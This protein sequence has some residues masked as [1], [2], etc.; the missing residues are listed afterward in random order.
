M[1]PAANRYT[2]VLDASV[3]FPQWKRDLLLCFFE[4]DLYR[5]QWSEQIQQEWLSNAIRKLPEKEHNLRR[6]DTLMRQHF[7]SAWIEENEY[8]QFIELVSLPDANDRHV[9]AAAIAGRADYIVT[10]NLKDFPEHELARFGIEVG[11][12]DKFLA[13]TF[14]HYPH[15]AIR[16]LNEH[17]LA[18]KNNPSASEYLM[19]LRQRG[20]PRLASQLQPHLDLI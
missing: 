19:L 4:A 15:S 17:R 14:E 20:L 2:V 3:L 11:S 12:A 9:V 6:A 1:I 8:V 10:D 5:A 13:G 18:L 16:V 7:G